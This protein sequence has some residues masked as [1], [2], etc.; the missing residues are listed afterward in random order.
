MWR[1]IELVKQNDR[2]DCGAAALATLARHYGQTIGLEKLRDLTDT[3]TSGASLLGL[4]KASQ[5]LGFSAKAI[6]CPGVDSLALMPLPAIAHVNDEGGVGHFVTILRRRKNRVLV[7]DPAGTVAWETVE[8]FGKRWTGHLLL[9]RPASTALTTAGDKATPLARF[10]RLLLPHRALLGEV[11][12]CALLMAFLTIFSS[13]FVQHLVDSVL[14]R[15][16]R[17]L[18]NALGLGM[19]LT[20]AFRA[21][22]GAVRHYLLAYIGRRI[23]LELLGGYAAH[24]LR[25]PMRFFE[26]RRVGEIYSRVTD[27]AKL[28]EAINGAATTVLVDG[29]VVVLLFG[30]LWMYDLRLA[31]AASLVAP[32]FLL[33]VGLHH[34]AIRR[35][36]RESMEAG[37]Q[38]SAHLIEDFSG[39]ETFKAFH[40]EDERLHRGDAKLVSFAQSVFALNKLDL[41]LSSLVALLASLAGLCMLWYGGHRV[42]DGALSIGQLM[43]FFTLLSS[44]LDPLSRLASVNLKLQDAMV[45]VDRLYQVLEI[46]QE[47][48][49]ASKAPFSRLRHGIELRDVEFSYGT[50]AQTIAGVSLTIPRGQTV[51]VVGESGSGKST[52]LKLLLQYYRPTG[53]RILID[54]MDLCDLDLGDYRRR[55]GVVA[56]DPFVFNGTIR[57]NIA[58]G[59][60]DASL[61][62]IVAAA[63]VAGLEEFIGRLP[64]RY[65]TPIGERGANLSG[66]ER[67]RLAIAR[68]LLIEPE[69]LIFDEATS[70]LDTATERTIQH[71]L[72]ERLTGRTVLI[73][74]HRLSTVKDADQIYVMHEGRIV[75][76]GTHAQLLAVAGRYAELWRAQTGVDAPATHN[77]RLNRLPPGVSFDDMAHV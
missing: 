33:L 70:H 26:T 3:D 35:R 48:F 47:P 21:A 1:R 8:E 62:Q 12:V 60:P 42:M 74:A 32:L 57:E 43:F 5:R 59:R 25:L 65:D 44:I 50:R 17:A 15:N 4:L 49:D 34:P 45:A 13:Y 10:M 40:A 38:L 29:V 23:D 52:L 24:V 58:L 39:I 16:D 9:A 46:D 72:R 2:S 41:Q 11:V 73:V 51:G 77:G 53:G 64:Q 71:N 37:A 19:A 68:A 18:L 67:Q 75:E 54:G 27:I 6:R 66:G 22:F 31:L 63:R 30:V 69:L 61:D 28:R 36:S 55:I 56:Q 7:G 14:V 76:C 20:A